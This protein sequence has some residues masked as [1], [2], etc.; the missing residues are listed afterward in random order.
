MTYSL[1]SYTLL[2]FLIIEIER[3]PKIVCKYMC[4]ADLF[5]IGPFLPR[6]HLFNTAESKFNLLVTVF[7]PN[8]PPTEPLPN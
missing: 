7:L 4:T 3:Q 6:F 5:K 2:Y 8:A 1:N